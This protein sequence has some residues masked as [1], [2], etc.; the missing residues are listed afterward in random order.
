MFTP[1]HLDT[2]DQILDTAH[3]AERSQCAH[4]LAETGSYRATPINLTNYIL[5]SLDADYTKKNNEDASVGLNLA[6]RGVW[7][8]LAQIFNF[9]FEGSLF[10]LYVAYLV[11]ERSSR[12]Q[13]FS[14]WL[15]RVCI[16]HSS[17][18]VPSSTEHSSLSQAL[19]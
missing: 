8:S 9:V 15:D 7:R 3:D 11:K 13:K 6:S 14:S 16:V 18:D 5:T 12:L 10:K 2:N 1:R 4:R 17:E 19:R